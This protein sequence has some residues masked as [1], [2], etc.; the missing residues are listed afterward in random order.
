MLAQRQTKYA[1]LLKRRPELQ[2][3]LQA[4]RSTGATLLIA[5]LSR[6]RRDAP[7]LF[8]LYGSGVRFIACDMPE[9]D[10]EL[11]WLMALAAEKERKKNSART[12]EAMAAAK[13]R[14]RHFGNPSGET[15][16]TMKQ[17]RQG[18]LEAL[19]TIRA[20]ARN[21]ALQLQDTLDQLATQGVTSASGMARALNEKC[22]LT[23]RGGRRHK[24]CSTE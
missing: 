20:R 23:T 4:C 3:A 15:C 16:L 21:F 8:N 10:R 17:R 1:D 18:N 13:A 24:F 2:A 5:R 12:K 22:V 7:F 19:K 6:L 11:V 14:G 9:A